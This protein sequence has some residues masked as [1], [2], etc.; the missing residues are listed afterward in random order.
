ML[1][2]VSFRCC[3]DRPR[4]LRAFGRRL[5]V[6]RLGARCAVTIRSSAFARLVHCSSSATMLGLRD[7]QIAPRLFS[8][9]VIRG[10]QVVRY[11][12][13][14]LSSAAR[15]CKASRSRPN[16]VHHL[17]PYP[18][19]VRRLQPSLGSDQLRRTLVCHLSPG[20]NIDEVLVYEPDLIIFCEGH[21]VSTAP[22]IR[23]RRVPRPR[24]EHRRPRPNT[25]DC[26]TLRGK[27]TAN[28]SAVR[29]IPRGAPPDDS[30][31]H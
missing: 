14:L 9:G 10:P 5:H 19:G 8:A 29:S 6:G 24:G 17:A 31:P 22:P 25:R 3:A 1:V 2:V 4:P 7:S 30:C 12:P 26:S 16:V 28:S 15:P 13:H 18:A 21:N 27:V 20:A 23:S 11:V